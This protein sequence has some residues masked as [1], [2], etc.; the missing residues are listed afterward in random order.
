MTKKILCLMALVAGLCSC[1]EDF[2]DWASP[3]SNTASEA[4][5]KMEMALQPTVKTVDFATETAETIQLF[6]TNLTND[7]VESYNVLLTATDIN[8]SIEITAD[9]DGKVASADLIG[10]VKELYGAAPVER[11]LSVTVSTEAKITTNDGD[12][13][14]KRQAAPFELKVTLDAPYID[15]NGYYYVGAVT[16]DKRYQLTNG[17][18][19]PYADPVFTGVIPA[20]DGDWHWFKLAAAC[21]FN[22]DGSFNW[23]NEEQ[24]CVGPTLKDD[25]STEG[26]C[27]YGKLSWHLIQSEEYV[28][29]RV[30][31]NM[32]EMTYKIEGI[33]AIPEYYGVGTMNGWDANT[34]TTAMFPTSSN[35]VTLT[36]YFTGAWD[37][38]FWPAENFGNWGAGTAIGT[39]INGDAA[40][41]GSLCWNT[42]NDGNLASP[43]AGYYTLDCDLGSMT[44]KWTKCDNQ[45]PATYEKIG[46]VGGNDDWDND[47]F[48]TQVVNNSGGSNPT[49]LWYALNVKIETCTWGVKF[50]VNGSWDVKDWG[51]G[52]QGFP[53]A[54]S[55]SGENIP[56]KPGTYNIYFNDITGH[57]FF[58]AQ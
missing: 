20:Y 8:K 23:D 1:T 12:I 45:T 52:E 37:M 27:G 40:P 55:N 3:Q 48:L 32:L 50:R 6:S 43:E 21:A 33:R 14:V 51:K 38:R 5:Q 28:A 24:Y 11:T 2:T 16:T 7:Q 42:E 58:V 53:Y 44:Y 26:Q 22:A 10:A 36:T 30:T 54:Q 41:S 34:K 29:Y 49:H 39:A 13:I 35:T 47:V 19:D 18:G 4:N 25:E 46:L 57:Y 31:I 9:S 56:L 17:G 15:P